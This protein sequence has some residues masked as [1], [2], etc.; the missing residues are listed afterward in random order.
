MCGVCAVL[1]ERLMSFKITVYSLHT[2]RSRAVCALATGAPE[3]ER[4]CIRD[5][6]SDQWIV[7]TVEEQ[8]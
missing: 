7:L 8:V 1:G 3:A 6:P 4:M 5:L 2:G